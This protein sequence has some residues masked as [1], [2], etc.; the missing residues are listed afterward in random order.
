MKAPTKL[1]EHAVE[2]FM[3]RHI[4]GQVLYE[5]AERRLNA[6]RA[7]AT[8]LEDIPDENQE[9]WVGHEPG[10]VQEIL[11]VVSD[12]TVRTVLPLGATRPKWRR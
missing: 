6:V 4:T 12:G 10:S 7:R 2:R 9:I 5:E 1:T 3:E 8:H 11:M